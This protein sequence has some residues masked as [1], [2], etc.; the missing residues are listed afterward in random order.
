[1][2]QPFDHVP[3]AMESLNPDSTGR[4]VLFIHGAWHGAWCWEDLAVS[5]AQAGW[6]VHLL[7]LPGHGTQAWPLPTATNPKHYAS[8]AAKAA[9]SLDKPVLIGHSMGGWIVQKLLEAVDLPAVLLAPLP[10]SGLP[11]VRLIRLLRYQNTLK[12]FIFRPMATN[13]PQ[14]ARRLFWPDMPDERLPSYLDALVPEPAF[15]ALAMS[16]GMPIL[17]LCRANPPVGRSPRLLV[18]AE[19]DYFFPP[20]AMKKLADKLGAD[21]TC[22]PGKPHNFWLDDQNGETANIV[23]NFL[24]NL[25]AD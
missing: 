7:E 9:A 11:F 24:E 13:T 8:Y 14:M 6:R 2:A 21:Y 25:P 16:A 4:D 10:G 15:V 12:L 3:V 19:N 1:M 22:L 18:A 5:T 20:A 23:I 17:H